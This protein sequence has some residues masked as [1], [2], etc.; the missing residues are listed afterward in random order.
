[1]ETRH[2]RSVMVV[3]DDLQLLALLERALGAELQL[4]LCK[5][6]CSAL[7]ALEDHTPDLLLLDLALPDGDGFQVLEQVSQR[8]PTP[9]VV[10]MSGTAAPAESFRLAQLGVHGYLTK[11]F[12]LA[13][14]RE[15]MAQAASRPLEIAPQLRTLVGQ[16]SIHEV[17]AE[18]RSTMLTEALARSSGS[19]RA[20]ARL[21]HVSRQL[22]QHM[23][24]KAGLD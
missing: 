3:D 13:E 14:L 22:V 2:I 8:Q 7:E 21:L 16:R 18:V 4:Q 23:L 12:D 15:A 5:D 20:A 1:M 17:E 6:A 11:P 24:R 9:L 10:V 19:R